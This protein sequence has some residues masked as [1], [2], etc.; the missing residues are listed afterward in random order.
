MEKTGKGW[1]RGEMRGKKKNE[2]KIWKK[3]EWKNRPNY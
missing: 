2:W 1:T 3:W